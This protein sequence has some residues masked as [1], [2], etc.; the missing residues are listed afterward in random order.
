MHR[1][2]ELRHHAPL[3]EDVHVCGLQGLRRVSH[4]VALVDVILSDVARRVR[5][6]SSAI[7]EHRLVMLG[8]GNILL[9]CAMAQIAGLHGLV[10]GTLVSACCFVLRA[11]NS[12]L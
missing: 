12:L 7:D 3:L 6:A 4:Q 2:G 10:S 8:L 9:D 5:A 11:A 1:R